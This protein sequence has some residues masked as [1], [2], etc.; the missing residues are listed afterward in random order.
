MK[1]SKYLQIA[2]VVALS[3][4]TALLIYVYA[5]FSYEN[6]VRPITD[7]SGIGM[8]SLT[9]GLPAFLLGLLL[10]VINKRRLLWFFWV[11]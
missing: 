4:Y 11:H 2:A 1:S 9:L 6:S 10:G 3:L 5:S 7:S 8:T